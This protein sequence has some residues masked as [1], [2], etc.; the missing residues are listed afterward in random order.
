MEDMESIIKMD[1]LYHAAVLLLSIYPKEMKYQED[2]CIPLFSAAQ[3]TTV[4][5]WNQP[6]C[7]L[8][9]EWIK[10]TWYML[11]TN[12]KAGILLLLQCGW[13]WRASC[14]VK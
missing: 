11:C 6:W 9:D 7:V 13:K 2:I 14:Y 3:F 10:K 12:G 8:K 5:I 1:L 4:K